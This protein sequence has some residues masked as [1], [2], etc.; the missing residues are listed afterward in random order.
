MGLSQTVYKQK[1][2]QWRPQS[3]TSAAAR[4]EAGKKNTNKKEDN[5]V[6]NDSAA[7][8]KAD[9]EDSVASCE[10]EKQDTVEESTTNETKDNTTID[11]SDSVVAV[12]NMWHQLLMLILLMFMKL[13]RNQKVKV[14]KRIGKVI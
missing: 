5:K 6:T 8:S 2:E 13:L 7:S 12:S 9:G 11:V 3:R 4:K 10:N 14:R 1:M